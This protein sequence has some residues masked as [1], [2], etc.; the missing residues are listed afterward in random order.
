MK[1]HSTFGTILLAV[2]IALGIQN[3][4]LRPATTTTAAPKESAYER[5]I[6]TNTLRCG[7]VVWPPF[8]AKD[9]T[10]GIMSG[11]FYDYMAALGTAL[12]IKIEWAEETG[13]G[14]FPVALETGRIDAECVSV[15]PNASRA[16]QV[17]FTNPIYFIAQ[18]I[19]VRA[20]D[21]RFDNDIKTIND[22]SVTIIAID[23]E[24]GGMVATNDFPKAKML[25]LSQM[26]APSDAFMSLIT[27]KA[28]VF[29]TDRATAKMFMDHNPRKIRRVLAQAPLRVFGN[30]IALAQGQDKLRRMLNTAT[31]EL[32]DSG[33]IENILY[34]YKDGADSLLHVAPAY[35][36]SQ[37]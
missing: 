6:R 19:Y 4:A 1:H 9:P 17:D 18:D 29:I 34:R 16:R 22:P 13:T 25:Q 14:D 11:L 20:E 3:F 8:I 23:G 5:V 7:Y 35:K 12:H 27:K 31:Q 33:Q 21:K 15:W 2:V 32:L 36:L 30:T 24:V 37:H 10:T 28:D 26:T